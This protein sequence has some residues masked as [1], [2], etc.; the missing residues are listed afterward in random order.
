MPSICAPWSTST[1]SAH[2]EVPERYS[3][4]MAQIGP[5]NSPQN[6]DLADESINRV[7]IPFFRVQERRLLLGAVDI[8]LVAAWI[9]VAHRLWLA[10]P[11]SSEPQLTHT[12]WD[13]IVGGTIVWFLVSWLAGA[14]ELDSAD[15]F[16][17]AS[18]VTFS[19]GIVVSLGA[20]VAYSFF[21]KTYPRPALVIALVGTPCSVL[22]WRGLY[23]SLLRR[24]AN[25]MRLLVVGNETLCETL[26]DAAKDHQSYYRVLGFVSERPGSG[27]YYL[28]TV[29]D[30]SRLAQRYKVHRI[31]VAP[32]QTL[33]H[34][35][36]A[37]LS[38]A[39]EH[40]LE[41]VDFNSAYEQIAEKVAVEHAGDYWLAALPT[42]PS[43]S[44]L[45]ELA[46][47]LLDVVGSVVGLALTA[48]LAP[49]IAAAIVLESGLPALYKQQ[50]LGRGGEPFTIFKF[51]SM[52]SDAELS[53][54]QWAV[55]KDLRTTHVGRLLRQTHLDELP[56]F[57]NVLRG[58]MSLVG[59]RPERPEFTAQLADVI[60]F[61]RLRLAVRPG[62]T[63]LK[64]I[65][66]GYA[67][68]AEEH[69]EVLRH[70]LYYIKR[71]SLALN[72]LVLARTVASVLGMDGR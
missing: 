45:E 28:G 68:T 17:S 55:K 30:L 58:E 9:G 25:A 51:R 35:L 3:V 54:A 63:G 71:R 50:R 8:L 15:R 44:S 20:F 67:A 31:V 27:Q 5:V 34:D 18:R 24:P 64:Q 42:C 12:P 32:R 39:I 43:T 33:P 11:H 57:W 37:T 46:M 14:Y 41:V 1:I 13:W 29:D 4:S 53:G 56:Q 7:S 52:R 70:D 62:L 49:F 36:V 6:I 59:P 65:K 22:L 66:F 19:V 16:W 2:D 10:H 23:A 69:L 26:A 61:Y 38:S 21:L 40:G 47:R 72:L 60:P 48:A